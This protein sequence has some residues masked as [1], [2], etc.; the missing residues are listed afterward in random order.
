MDA[1][2]IIDNFRKIVTRHYVDFEGRAR[3]SQ[4]WYFVLVYFV[5]ALVLSILQQ[6]VGLGYL[7]SGLLG[8]A[9][10]LPNLSLGVRRLHDTNKSG[11]WILIG[12]IPI[13]GWIA[14][15]YFYCQPGTAGSN[16]FGADPKAA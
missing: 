15:I 3:R 10:L 4:F 6:I 9:L 7:L 5:I 2:G 11:W 16:T 12:I 14:L 1:N 13:L 8:I